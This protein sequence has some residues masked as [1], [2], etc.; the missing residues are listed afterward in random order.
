MYIVDIDNTHHQVNLFLYGIDWDGPITADTDEAADSVHVAET[1]NP[2]EQRDYS[3]LQATIS[4]FHDSDCYGIDLYI[5]TL[6]FV[7]RKLV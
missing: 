5:Q 2:L 3:E 7:Y 4:P 1:L 6:E